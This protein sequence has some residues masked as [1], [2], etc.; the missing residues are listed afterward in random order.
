[1]PSDRRLRDEIASCGQILE[2]VMPLSIGRLSSNENIIAAPRIERAV[3]AVAIQRH[4]DRSQ[5]GI[6]G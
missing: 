4:G 5:D 3:P 2:L 6:I 1:M